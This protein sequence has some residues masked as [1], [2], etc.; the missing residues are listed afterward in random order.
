MSKKIGKWEKL[1]TFE[2]CTEWSFEVGGEWVARIQ[3]ERPTR[4][5][6]NGVG[7]L[8]RDREAP[9]VWCADVDGADVEIPNG[10]TVREAKALVLQALSA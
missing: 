6:A 9:W 4:W 8:V 10:A 7:G 5:H 2:G 3:R 1:G